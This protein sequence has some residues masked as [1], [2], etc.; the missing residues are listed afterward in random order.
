MK[1]NCTFYMNPCKKMD[2]PPRRNRDFNIDEPS[3]KRRRYNICLPDDK[4][5]D[6]TTTT[7]KVR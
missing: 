7:V 3:P 2:V 5:S 6:V 4:C 1:N